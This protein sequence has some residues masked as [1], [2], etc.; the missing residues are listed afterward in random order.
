V[1]RCEAG[2]GPAA[3]PAR[4]AGG[5]PEV[6]GDQPGQQEVIDRAAGWIGV[7]GGHGNPLMTVLVYRHARHDET[8]S[9]HPT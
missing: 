1:A 7:A 9:K 5:I 6:G 2:V 4:R 3:G 8:D